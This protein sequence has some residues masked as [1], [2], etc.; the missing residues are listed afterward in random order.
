MNLKKILTR[1]FDLKDRLLIGYADL[2]G[3]PD[4]DRKGYY[5]GI[6]IGIA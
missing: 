1:E 3:L 6:S 5:Y 4:G 2:A